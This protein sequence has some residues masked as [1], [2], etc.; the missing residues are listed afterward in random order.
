MPSNNWRDTRNI[1]RKKPILSS[2]RS[3][4]NTFFPYCVY[5]WNSLKSDIRKA[6]SLN[7]F[8]ILYE[9]RKFFISRL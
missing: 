9:K 5:E 8:K 1:K 6:K 2:T 3:I 4:R 7:I